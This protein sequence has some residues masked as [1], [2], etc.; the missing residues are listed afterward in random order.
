MLHRN[1]LLIALSAFACAPPPAALPTADLSHVAVVGAD[2][3][4]TN[5]AT[6]ANGRVTV[7]SLWAPWCEGCQKEEPALLRLQ[8]LAE[9]RGDFVLVSIAIGTSAD[10]V[11]ARP[12]PRL[13]DTG[14]FAEFGHRR[15]PATLVIDA[16]GRTV[17][18]G[19][20]LDGAALDALTKALAGGVP[21][22][23]R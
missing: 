3:K 18:E 12:Y 20:A 8:Q 6:L 2:G 21:T 19:G 1:L 11:A 22:Q 13:I 7:A 17:F 9:K 10:D 23:T 16:S 5:L 15:V 14:A 4:P